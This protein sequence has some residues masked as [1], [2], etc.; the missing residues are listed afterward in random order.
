MKKLRTA[1]I[2]QG[3]SGR[4]IHGKFYKS[5]NNDLVEVVTVVEADP[6]RRDRALAEYPGC[7]VCADYRELFARDDLDLVVNATFSNDH[8]AITKD[9]LAHGFNVLVEKPFARNYYECSDLIKLAKDNNV[10]LAVFHQS[11]LA[12]H[13]LGVK[14][15]L[16]S[17]KLGDIKQISIRYNGLARRW[18]WQTLQMKMGG[19]VYNTGPHPI[20]MALD[21]LDFDKNAKVVYSKLDTA[22][23]SGDA[24]D[25]A[26]ILITAPEKPLVD[27]EINST[28]AYCNYTVKI[29]G[30]KG[31][32][33]CTASK[34]KMKYIVD[35]ENP[36]RPPIVESLKDADGYPKYC[37]ELLKTHE[38][39]G[40]YTGSAFDI[41]VQKFYKMLYAKIVDGTPMEICPEKIAQVIN[42]IE[43][44]HAD[45]PLPVKYQ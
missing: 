4:D 31:T 29:Q 17:G 43:K 38:E 30:S 5:E 20:G 15:V 2:G 36:E 40:D 22:L 35:G 39:E 10:T 34:Y 13:H 45:N 3:R 16:E 6:E 23:T 42:V 32:F 14:E 7:T 11:L 9:L 33:S 1:I 28:D 26:K 24:E 41:A 27:I 44:V 25:Y 12:P 19:S 21:Y 37:W 8:Y 18:D